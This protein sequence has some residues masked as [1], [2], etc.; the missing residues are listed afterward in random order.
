MKKIKLI[1]FLVIVLIFSNCVKQEYDT[2]PIQTIPTGDILSIKDLY[3]IN[4]DSIESGIYPAAYKFTKDLSVYAVVCMDDKT[5]NIYK[6]AYIQ[7]D[8]LGINLHLMASGGIR[9]GDKIRIN[10]KG[11]V[12][13]VY[14]GM[15]QL[16]SVDADKNIVIQENLVSISPITTTISQLNDSANSNYYKS[17][18][19]KLENVHFSNTNQTWAD[20][21]NLESKDVDLVDDFG[22]TIIIRSSGY[23]SFAGDTLPNG[24]GSLMA[25]YTVYGTTPQLVVRTP[26]ETSFID[27]DIP[28]SY[29]LKKNFEDGSLTSGGWQNIVVSGTHADWLFFQDASMSYARI[30]NEYNFSHYAAETWFVSPSFSLDTATTPI[31]TFKNA[32]DGS[33]SDLEVL[34][35]ADYDGVSAPSTATWTTLSPILSSG[36]LAWTLSGDIDLSAYKQQNDVYISFK[37]TGTST[38]GKMWQIDDVLI[39]EQ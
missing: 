6:S 16:D 8:T 3:Q 35:S 9:Q 34:I 10:L 39:K 19:I 24:S 21:V 32:S 37:Y 26:N 15:L 4:T 29:Y 17:R 14:K 18:L 25:I 7:D 2:P 22:N 30:T 33:G 1:S 38:D 5:G 27:T 23:A 36:S 12:L 11:L 31:L 13:G 28:G 20:A